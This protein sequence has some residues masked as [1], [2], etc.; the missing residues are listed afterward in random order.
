VNTDGRY[1]VRLAWIEDHPPVPININLAK[2]R[3]ENTLRRLEKGELRTAYDEI[4]EDWLQEGIIEE[5]SMA[6]WDE[7]HYLIDPL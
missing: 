2:K 6:Q 7:G 5:M 4:F 1:E 3:S